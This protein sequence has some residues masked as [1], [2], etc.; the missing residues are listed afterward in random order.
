LEDKAVTTNARLALNLLAG[1]VSAF[2][3]SLVPI[4]LFG[5]TPIYN[6]AG[7]GIGVIFGCVL[8]NHLQKKSG[9]SE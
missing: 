5:S 1:I 2:L 7:I 9:R 4:F 6:A 8:Y 3:I